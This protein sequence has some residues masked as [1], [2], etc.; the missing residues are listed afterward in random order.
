[1]KERNAC[2]Y[3]GTLLK[4]VL[5]HDNSNSFFSFIELFP[6]S[7]STFLYSEKSD[8]N[9]YHPIVAIDKVFEYS[10]SHSKF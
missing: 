6:L 4:T 5:R 3:P 7:V 8:F 2:K 1:M 10:V 9:A